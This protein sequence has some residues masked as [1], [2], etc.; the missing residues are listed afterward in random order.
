MAFIRPGSRV[1]VS[2]L[3]QGKNQE[4]SSNNQTTV[5]FFGHWILVIEI[6]LE[7][8]IW[9]LKIEALALF[10]GVAQLVTRP[11][12]RQPVVRAGSVCSFEKIMN[13]D[14]QYVV[15]VLQDDRGCLYKGMTNNLYRRL[16]EHR[17]GK[18]Q[19][20]RRMHNIKIVYT[21]YYPTEQE[22]FSRERYLK[23]A[24]GRRFLN[25]ILGA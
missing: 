25:K 21:E 18:T 12:G 10:G 20:T 13:D 17:R 6:Y 2:P 7:I 9:L 23:S 11:T 3:L 8:S 22:A 16:A 5:I 4:S 24:A 14:N 19:T 1:R 15:Y